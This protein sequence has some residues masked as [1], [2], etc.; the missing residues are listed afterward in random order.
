MFGLQVCAS[1]MMSAITMETV[2]TWKAGSSVVT[3]A[4][5]HHSGQVSQFVV[6][7]RKHKLDD[8]HVEDVFCEHSSN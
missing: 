3:S 1:S 5:P 7:W 6:T 4:T 8:N 2:A